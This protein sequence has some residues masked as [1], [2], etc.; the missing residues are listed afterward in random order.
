MVQSTVKFSEIE[1]A[2]TSSGE[3]K[4]DSQAE[5]LGTVT[6][7]M[8]INVSY[9]ISKALDLEGRIRKQHSFHC[10]TERVLRS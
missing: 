4:L 3:V 9:S 8:E 2:H 6:V 10:I 7:L 1:Y 5:Y